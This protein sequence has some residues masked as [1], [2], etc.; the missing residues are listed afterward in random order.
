MIEHRLGVPNVKFSE[1]LNGWQ[2]GFWWVYVLVY[3]LPTVVIAAG[4]IRYFNLHGLQHIAPSTT[5]GQ[6]V[7]GL[8]TSDYGDVIVGLL[9]SFVFGRRPMYKVALD[10]QR[11][12]AQR[13]KNAG[14]GT[15]PYDPPPFRA[16]LHDLDATKAV[17]V[18]SPRWEGYALGLVSTLILA[19]AIFGYIV[20]TVIA[21]A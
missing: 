13:R 12:F 18:E 9:A 17:Q 6:K 7:V 20:L 4:A 8:W 19:L 2:L 21:K 1:P 3:A 16:L 14:R 10:V 11:R 5:Y 15:R